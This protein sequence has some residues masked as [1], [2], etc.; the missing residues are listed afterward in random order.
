M[1]ALTIDE[2]LS[3]VQKMRTHANANQSRMNARTNVY[4][5]TSANASQN[6]ALSGEDG[7]ASEEEL[8]MQG[9][10]GLR[11]RLFVCLLVFSAFFGLYKMNIQ[12][13]GHKVT[14]VTTFLEENQLPKNAQ[15]SLETMAKQLV[16]QFH[17]PN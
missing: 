15:T 11:L 8:A 2:K 5:R 4:P 10:G 3:L 16:E 17:E 1:S 13:K 12:I 9:V 6:L 7:M 14:E